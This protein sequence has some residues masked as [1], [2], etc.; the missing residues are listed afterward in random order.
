M[1]ENDL[2]HTSGI[3]ISSYR[4]WVEEKKG[5]PKIDSYEYPLYTDS[6][7]TGEWLDSLGPY[8]LFNL[9][10]IVNE[11]GLVRST[12]L[13]RVDNHIDHNLLPINFNKTNIDFFHGGTLEDE[14]AA[15]ISL[16]LG[17]R[18]KAGIY[19]RRFSDSEKDP[20]GT[21]LSFNETRIPILTLDK[22]NLI[23]VCFSKTGPIVMKVLSVL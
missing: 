9:I 23:L 11:P 8:K 15:L 6:H 13:L 7:I 21:P 16:T 18:I 17:A 22:R 3:G 20:Y 10:P 14:M 12:I 19:C 1:S 4:N 2:I 5:A